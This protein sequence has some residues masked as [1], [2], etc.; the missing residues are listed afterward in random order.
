MYDATKTKMLIDNTP[1]NCALNVASAF[2]IGTTKVPNIPA[3]MWA[4]IAPTTSSSLNE[5]SSL[6][7]NTTITTHS[8]N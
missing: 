5:N 4:G 6:V 2:V 3:N 1:I 8:T 7:P